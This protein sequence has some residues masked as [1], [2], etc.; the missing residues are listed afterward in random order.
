MWQT[1][2]CSAEKPDVTAKTKAEVLDSILDGKK[3]FQ[4]A[5]MS[6]ELSAQGDFEILR[7]L[8]T[9]FRFG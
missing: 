4:V 6:G 8:D 9:I 2:S 7:N 5:F 3:S 1:E